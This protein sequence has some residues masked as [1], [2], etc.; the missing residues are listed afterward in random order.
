MEN[1]MTD[2]H[3]PT[4]WKVSIVRRE[5]VDTARFYIEDK[6]LKTICD[7]YFKNTGNEALVS[8]DNDRANANLIA[9]APEMLKSLERIINADKLFADLSKLKKRP[10]LKLMNALCEQ[11]NARDEAILIIKKAQGQS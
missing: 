7:L 5:K 2:K 11:T 4:P 1:I 8:F 6:N 10:K 9:T 3:T